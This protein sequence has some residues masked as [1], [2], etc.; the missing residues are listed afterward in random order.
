MR[1]QHRVRALA[2][3]TVVLGVGGAM[4]FPAAAQSPTNVFSCRASAG[5]ATSGSLSPTPLTTEPIRA[6][7]ALTPCSTQNAAV[8]GPATF[9]APPPAPPGNSADVSSAAAHTSRASTGVGALAGVGKTTV[10]FAGRT[11]TFDSA[12]ASV[13]YQCGGVGAVSTT[14]SQIVKLALD[15]Q[16]VSVPAG[17]RDI[18]LTGTDATLHL[19][20]I[21]QAGNIITVRAIE[22]ESV[23]AGDLVIA[24]AKAGF[25]GDVTK[26]CGDLAGT[27]STST[28]TPC[29]AG[30][31]FDPTRDACVVTITGPNGQPTVTI[32]G[33][34]FQ[35]A[36]NGKVGNSTGPGATCGRLEMHFDRNKKKSFTSKSGTRVV[37]R[38]SV[39]GCGADSKKPIVDA[40]IDQIHILSGN[41]RLTKTGLKSRPPSG[42]LTLILPSNVTSRS[43]EFDYRPNLASSQVASRTVLKLTVKKGR[44]K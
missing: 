44:R 21:Q 13:I 14:S 18:A 28:V 2:L 34:P 25:S 36:S 8:T 27:P 24:E 42:E 9:I 16:A 41:R 17:P 6:N 31:T 20:R 11:L 10:H 32:A 19:N 7:D 40:K 15:G 38:G 33:Q 5:R 35:A 4:A 30:A 39:H 22:L 43:I 26:A 1:Q 3:A 23:T 29:Q 37:I 12:Q